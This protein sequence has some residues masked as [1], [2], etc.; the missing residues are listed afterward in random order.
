MK[1]IG[2]AAQKVA[3]AE[4]RKQMPDYHWLLMWGE[5]F[6]LHKGTLAELETPADLIKL[7]DAAPN[8]EDLL[9][10]V[11]RDALMMPAFEVPIT[12]TEIVSGVR[13]FFSVPVVP[14]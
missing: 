6:V 14:A 3:R 10:V 11:S 1:P 8:F 9:I 4:L 2:E 12:A 7:L 13:R 5:H